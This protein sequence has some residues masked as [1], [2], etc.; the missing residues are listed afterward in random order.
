MANECWG[1]H[2]AAARHLAQS[3]LCPRRRQGLKYVGA[4]ASAWAEGAGL[5]LGLSA[6]SGDGDG[7][8][9]P[10][11]SKTVRL[12]CDDLETAEGV[13]AAVRAGMHHAAAAGRPA[14]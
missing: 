4:L 1:S 13:V 6:G 9:G 8:P 7:G 10:G 14:S 11:G 5:G 12:E 3:V 2:A